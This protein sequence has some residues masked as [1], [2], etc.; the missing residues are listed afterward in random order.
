MI[1]AQRLALLTLFSI[2]AFSAQAFAQTS[3][4]SAASVYGSGGLQAAA[5]VAADVNGDGISDLLVLNG[6]T[7]SN[8]TRGSVGVLIGNGDGTYKAA[9][10]YDAGAGEPTSGTAAGGPTS[11]AT[12]DVNG[13]GKLDLIVTSGFGLTN[14]TVSVLLGNGDGTFHAL[15]SYP[16]GGNNPSGLAVADVNGDGKLDIVVANECLLGSDSACGGPGTIGVLLGNGD[17]TFQAAQTYATGPRCAPNSIAIADLNGDGK[18]D[19][20]F[21]GAFSSCNASLMVGVG[22]GTFQAPTQILAA[23][24]YVTAGDLN[25]DGKIDILVVTPGVP[26]A[27]T[28]PAGTLNVLLGNGTGSF[29]LSQSTAVPV[30]APV[31]LADVNGDG[32]LDLVAGATCILCFNSD[33]GVFLGNGDGTFQSARMFEST[34]EVNVTV[35]VADLNGDGKLDI[36][37]VNQCA[38]NTCSTGNNIGVLFGN[39]DGTFRASTPY[40]VAGLQNASYA[41]TADLNG[42]G[43]LDLVFA[44]QHGLTG[45]SGGA[46]VFLGNGDGTFGSGQ[47]YSSGGYGTHSVVLADVNKDGKLDLVMANQCATSSLCG[48]TD[49]GQVAI[50]LGNG[51]GTFQPVQTYNSGG[52][53]TYSIA[54]ADLNADGNL[55]VVVANGNSSTFTVLLGNGDGTFQSATSFASGGYFPTSLAVTDVN[56]DGKPDVLVSNFCPDSTC[57]SNGVI[58]VQ[59]G[60]GHGSFTPFQSYSSGGNRAGPLALADLN[61]DG[62]LDIAVQNLCA[63]GATP[64]NCLTGTMGVL[65][66]NGDGTFQAP[67]TTSLLSGYTGSSFQLAVTDFDGDGKLDIAM[68]PAGVLLGNG[69]GTFQAPLVLSA[70]GVGFVPGDFNG[71]GKMDLAVGGGNVVVLLND[72]LTVTTTSLTTSGTPTVSGHSVTFT[73]TVTPTGPR[74]PTGN[75]TFSDGPHSLGTSP[76]SGG[77]ATLSTSTLA[78]GTHSITASYAGNPSFA[79]SVSNSLTQT[80]NGL[81]D[82]TIT[83][84]SGAQTVHPGQQA[85]FSLTVMPLNGSTQSVTISCT[86]VPALATCSSGTPSVTL[87]G[88]TGTVLVVNVSTTANSFVPGRGPTQF[89]PLWIWSIAVAGILGGLAICFSARTARRFQYVSIYLLFIV[90]AAS[91]AGCGTKGETSTVT[92]GTNPNPLGTAAGTYTLTVTGTSGTGASAQSHSTTVTLVVN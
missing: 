32:K 20:L 52:S 10:T 74:T 82:F 37:A 24:G 51:D 57:G 87:N 55:D 71:D 41:A 34:G 5:V 91:A 6:C 56:G 65:L 48:R 4:F 40:Q 58:S 53:G 29:T 61:G 67:T 19:L 31:V 89:P 17:G 77:V 64:Q 38:N 83:S 78:V 62:K 33:V 44:D 84:A 12:G 3:I 25:G 75:V 1:P 81:P 69:D 85:N 66:G 73:A 2:S 35:A 22:D 68:G 14:G 70:A 90:L 30:N 79:S 60:D 63:T 92:G 76:L 8:C 27:T 13:D 80:V 45:T 21:D 43:K 9:V 42:D 47:S 72:I 16:S 15:V 28:S 36:A 59:L 54:V 23:S 39:G 86:G 46:L 49:N 88:S 11:I 7:D 50:L 18:A 26:D